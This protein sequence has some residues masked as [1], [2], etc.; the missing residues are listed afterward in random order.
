MIRVRRQYPEIFSYFPEQL[1]DSNICKVDVTGCEDMLAYARY[2]GDTA[3]LI[4]PNYNIHDQSGK[5]TVYLPFE[6]MGLDFYQSYTVTDAI[7]GER[8]V[9]GK[10][11]E[12]AKF[13]VVVP[14]EDMR[15][16][17]VQASGKYEVKNDPSSKPDDG[18]NS[19]PDDNP[20]GEPSSEPD[21][22]PSSDPGNSSDGTS[23]SNPDSPSGT[24]NH[25]PVAN[26]EEP[27]SDSPTLWIIL[28]VVGG[29]V[30]LGGAGAAFYVMRKRSAK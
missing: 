17:K 30:I 3:I 21:D 18:P 4:V 29:V 9:S 19:E 7:T 8:I 12:V 27:K 1:R 26:P 28:G 2:R 23:S 16:I 6:D 14:S 15:V 11:N 5:M 13:S 22:N 24:T 10:A 25:M 20:S